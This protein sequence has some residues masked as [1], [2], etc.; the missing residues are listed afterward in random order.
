MLLMRLDET[1]QD[2]DL[3]LQQLVIHVPCNG[4]CSPV[5]S[6][7]R[8]CTPVAASSPSDLIKHERVNRAIML[9]T[10]PAMKPLSVA[11]MSRISSERSTPSLSVV[12]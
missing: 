11:A 9:A 2:V 3:N 5:S 7:Y 4:Y 8:L 1:E 6:V 10:S 12:A